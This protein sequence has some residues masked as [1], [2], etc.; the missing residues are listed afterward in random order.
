MFKH[1][2]TAIRN[3]N[4]AET[5][6]AELRSLSDRELNDMGISRYDIGRIA[7][8]SVSGPANDDGQPVHANDL[9]KEGQA[10][11]AA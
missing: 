2:I 4:R 9:R 6:A 11:L 8:L 5:V 1:L 7:W 10:D 3:W